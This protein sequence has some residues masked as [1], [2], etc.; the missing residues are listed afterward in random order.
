[1]RINDY[2]AHH[3]YEASS[4]SLGGASKKMTL[5]K[6]N[7]LVASLIRAI[8]SAP[9]AITLLK[10]SE[11]CGMVRWGRGGGVEVNK[12]VKNQPDISLSV[13]QMT[14][15]GFVSFKVLY[16]FL[17]TFSLSEVPLLFRTANKFPYFML[18]CKPPH[19]FFS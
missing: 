10:R 4:D 16:R 18:Y 12:N 9:S 3:K 6:V 17:R 11:G 1:M 8:P 19:S 2:Q 13:K 15:L 14:I 5:K 7:D